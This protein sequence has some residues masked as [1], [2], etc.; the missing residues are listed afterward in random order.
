[1]L[2]SFVSLFHI[3]IDKDGNYK[4]TEFMDWG[5]SL[6]SMATHKDDKVIKYNIY[7]LLNNLVVC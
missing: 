3:H 6:I 2:P 7:S 4:R 5:S 1:M